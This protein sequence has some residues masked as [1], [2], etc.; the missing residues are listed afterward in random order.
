[1]GMLGACCY[2]GHLAGNK[3]KNIRRLG[4]TKRIHGTELSFD[5]PFGLRLTSSKFKV[6]FLCVDFL[7]MLYTLSH[8]EQ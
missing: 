7:S 4:M 3:S 2:L 8:S 1:M 6:I 5:L